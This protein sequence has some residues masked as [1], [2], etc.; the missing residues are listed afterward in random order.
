MKV[1]VLETNLMWSAR[2]RQSLVAF[3]HEAVVAGVVPDGE[4]DLAIVNLGE[5]KVADQVANLKARGISILGH[6]GHKGK[7]L[8][9]LGR[10]LGIDRLA[11]NSQLTNKLPEL[12]AAQKKEEPEGSPI[13]N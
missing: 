7:D 8:M 12:V 13:V 3:G 9:A 11:T 4:F 10:E 1:L 6:A 2:L 5:P